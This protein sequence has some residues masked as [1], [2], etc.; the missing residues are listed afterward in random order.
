MTASAQEYCVGFARRGWTWRGHRDYRT[1]HI[2]FFYSSERTSPLLSRSVGADRLNGQT[3]RFTSTL[4]LFSSLNSSP[5]LETSPR[6]QGVN[7]PLP[8]TSLAFWSRGLDLHSRIV[9]D[10]CLSTVLTPS[11]FHRQRSYACQDKV[12]LAPSSGIEHALSPP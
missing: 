10:S 7:P 8:R 9:P 2:Y 12:K 6:S 1:N 4:L 11:R 3:F 5:L